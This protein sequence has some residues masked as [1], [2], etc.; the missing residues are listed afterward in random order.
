MKKIYSVILLL[1][2]MLSSCTKD[3]TDIITDDNSKAPALAQTRSGNSAVEYEKMPNPYALS[4]MQGVYDSYKVSKKLEPTDLYVRFLP[5][6]SLQLNTL[7]YNYNLE[8][9][10]YPLDIEI[11]EDTVYTDPTIPE[12]GFTWLYTTVKPDFVFPKEIRHEVI[13]ECYIPAEDE[14]ISPTRGGIVNVEEAAFLSL[15]YNIDE[16]DSEGGPEARGLWVRPKGTIKVY[17]NSLYTY[18]PVK[19]VKIRCH[20]VVKW[21]TTFTNDDGYYRMDSRFLL[22]PHYAIVFDNKQDFDIW[23]NWGP[24]ARANLNMG[25]H[26][27]KGYSRNIEAG[28]FAW[29]WAATNNAGYDYYKMCEAT[30]IPKP[31]RNLKI[32]V[33][34][35]WSSSSA[36]MLRRIVHPIDFTGPISWGNFFF[37]INPSEIINMLRVFLPDITIGTK[38]K[39]YRK[40]YDHV[41]HELSHASHFS[42]VGSAYWARY[43]GYIMTNQG[44]G[45]GSGKNA[46]LCGVGEMWGYSMGHIQ[47]F[48]KYEPSGLLEKYKFYNSWMKPH[49]FWD[50]YRGNTLT[51]KQI[52]DCLAVGVDTYDKLVAKMYERYPDKADAIEKAFTDNGITPNVPKPDSGNI[53]HDAFYTDKTVSSSF[54]F[55]GNNILTRNVTVTNNAKLTF[56]ANK[57]VTINSPFTINQGAQLAITCGN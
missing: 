36:P 14:E 21:S 13:E 10:D 6:D 2:V 9:F 26:S 53:T 29:P 34:K 33:F 27:K 22:R 11:P 38:G 7:K 37:D 16:E 51:K 56:H 4:V 49:V 24:I 25:W 12:G 43:I 54:V 19:G 57:S 31:P 3:E 5:Q 17:D 52:Y 18:V 32:Y 47:E 28:S 8:L 42:A 30:G 15:G 41:N 23:G 48:E 35:G 20:V 55:S 46:E 45:N 39:S 44:Y 1:A 40:V 50:L